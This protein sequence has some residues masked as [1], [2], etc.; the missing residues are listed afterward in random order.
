MNI[1]L[2]KFLFELGVHIGEHKSRVYSKNT[3]FLLGIRQN[4]HII[5]IN[6]TIYFLKNACNFIKNVGK[7][8]SY[9]FFYYTNLATLNKRLISFF[10]YH[11]YRNNHSFLFNNWKHGLLSNYNMQAIDIIIDLFPNNNNSKSNVQFTSLLFKMLYYTFNTREAGIRWFKHLK[12][13][14]KYW[15]FF[16]FYSF[17]RNLNILPEVAVIVN[18]NQMITPIRECNSLKIPVVGLVDSNINSNN[19]T[20]PIPGNDNSFLITA[21]LFILLINCY[22]KGLVSNINSY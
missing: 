19:Y 6:V 21:F 4:L 5:D 22:K 8:N 9:L 20:Y 10:L 18:A 12:I 17:F 3:F 7:K 15:R 13:M 1:Q 11:L 16:S 14:K 2:T